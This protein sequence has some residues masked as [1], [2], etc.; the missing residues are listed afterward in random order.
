MTFKTVVGDSNKRTIV[1]GGCEFFVHTVNLRGAL[2]NGDE[3]EV[4]AMNSLV[5]A[6]WFI[7][8]AHTF[9]MVDGT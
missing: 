6:R 1:Y 2:I 7:R 5:S 9:S 4:N 8:S 3:N